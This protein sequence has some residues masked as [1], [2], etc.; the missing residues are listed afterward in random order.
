[1]NKT[2]WEFHQIMRTWY[3]CLIVLLSVH[4]K[5]EPEQVFYEGWDIGFYEMLKQT[6]I[7]KLFWHG[8]TTES[9]VPSVLLFTPDIHHQKLLLHPLHQCNATFLWMLPIDFLGN[10]QEN[11][12]ESKMS[13]L[14]QFLRFNFIRNFFIN[15]NTFM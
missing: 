8:Q 7:I 12:Y 13:V 4:N 15:I 11:S 5:N 1:M 3:G 2:F 9:L 10:L 6:Y 14:S